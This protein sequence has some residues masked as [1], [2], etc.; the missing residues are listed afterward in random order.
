MIRLVV[1]QTRPALRIGAGLPRMTRARM[2]DF[3]WPVDINNIP[4]SEL[5]K[6]RPR[7]QAYA[8]QAV[9]TALQDAHMVMDPSE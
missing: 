5:D 2:D 8:D 3:N 9:N 4:Q 7:I 6:I 1:F